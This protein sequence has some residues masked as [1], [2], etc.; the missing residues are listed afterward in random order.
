MFSS[1]LKTIQ[2]ITLEELAELQTELRAEPEDY[3]VRACLMVCLT[4]GIPPELNDLRTEWERS[5]REAKLEYLR[6]LPIQ[7]ADSNEPCPGVL[8]SEPAA[9]EAEGLPPITQH[10]QLWLELEWE[11]LRD[12][13]GFKA[14]CTTD[15]LQP[16]PLAPVSR[17]PPPLRRRIFVFDGPAAR[18][19]DAGAITESTSG[20][21]AHG[22]DSSDAVP[23]VPATDVSAERRLVDPPQPPP[24]DR[25]AEK[26][27]GERAEG[28]NQSAPVTRQLDVADSTDA[29]AKDAVSG[30]RFLNRADWFKARL[31]ERGWNEHDLY[32][33]GG[34]EYRTTQ[35]KIFPGLI[36]LEGVLEKAITALNSKPTHQGRNLPKLSRSDI[37]ND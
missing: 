11:D 26:N 35:K 29:D 9:D 2:A 20:S 13:F 1:W 36:V 22:S 37:P 25:D 15:W 6:S 18:K 24:S 8:P 3:S 4:I 5:A 30:P 31:K 27:K 14:G 28:P 10:V 19:S 7:T 34:P 21:E 23:A 33:A 17:V 32:D 12:Q 16:K